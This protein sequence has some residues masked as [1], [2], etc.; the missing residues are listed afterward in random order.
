MLKKKEI[1]VKI[2]DACNTDNNVVFYTCLICGRRVCYNCKDEG[3]K[4]K[5][6]VYFYGGNGFYCRSCVKDNPRDK[7][8]LAYQ[9]ILDLRMEATAWNTIFDKKTKEAEAHLE[10]LRDEK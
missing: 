6:G 8:L 2:C 7:L 5:N 10:Q 3:I 9:A 1:E 4:Y